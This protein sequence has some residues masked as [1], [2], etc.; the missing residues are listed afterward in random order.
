MRK[1]PY[2]EGDWFAVPLHTTGYGV[3]VVARMPRGG[4][5]LLGYFFGPRRDRPPALDEVSA[6]RPAQAVRALR[7]GD[8]GLIEGKWPLIG[9]SPDWDRARWPMPTFVRTEPIRGM[10]WT[11]RYPDDDPLGNPTL[12]RLFESPAAYERDAIS[13][14]GAVEIVLTADLDSDAKSRPAPS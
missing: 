5:V 6:L 2:G 4:K 3:G 13:G 8:L 10:R 12:E 11:A 14:A 7:F 1:L 9:R